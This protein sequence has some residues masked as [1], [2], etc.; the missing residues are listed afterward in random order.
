MKQ[1]E[2]EIIELLWYLGLQETY[3]LDDFK[4]E[5]GDTIVELADLIKQLKHMY[6][7]IR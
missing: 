1:I 3:D 7:Q 4:G 5:I 2:E 6:E